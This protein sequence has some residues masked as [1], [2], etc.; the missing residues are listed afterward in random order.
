MQIICVTLINAGC[1]EWD[2]KKVFSFK[3]ILN[4][5]G[6]CLKKHAFQESL[7]AEKQ[8]ENPIDN[9]LR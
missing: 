4:H 9:D 8:D 3:K 1:C 7:F 2:K 5:L 6:L